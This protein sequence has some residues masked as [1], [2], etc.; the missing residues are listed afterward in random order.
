MCTAHCAVV[1]PKCWNALPAHIR[2]TEYE[3][4]FKRI[5]YKKYITISFFI[6]A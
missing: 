6:I 4:L 3:P 5:V 2:S 1:A